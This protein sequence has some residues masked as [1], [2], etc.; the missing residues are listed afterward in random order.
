VEQVFFHIGESE[1]IAGDDELGVT[2]LGDIEQLGV[3][4]VSSAPGGVAPPLHVH[5]RHAEAFF[6]FE[7]ELTF[8]LEDGEHKAERET[9]V[10]I[11]PEVVH[12]FA[13]TGGERAHFLDFHV[14]S[15][16]FGDF[17]R[18]LHAA[19]DEGELRAVRAAFD[20]RP[21]PEYA[22]GD[23]GLAVLRRTGGSSGVGSTEPPKSAGAGS[24][25][26]GAG[27]GETIVDRPGRRLTLLVEADELTVTEFVHG[28]GERGAEP[29]IHHHH[30]DGFLVVEGELTFSYR[31]GS[32]AAPAGTF[33]LVPP[34]VVHGF[35]NEGTTSVRCFNFHAP[36][37]GFGDHL[38]QRNPDFDQHDP[39]ADGGVDPA[40]LIAV[41]LTKVAV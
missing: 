33:L 8:R 30:A 18:G 28:P 5:E 17:A 16:G 24:A 19:R 7:G 25:G 36:S 29:H 21:A 3:V 2:L 9:W 10:F 40:S 37:L 38:R 20:Q 39:P 35:D 13:V 32:F 26:A 34:G 14:P 1:R 27:S 22:A 23:P 15:L 41:R 4:E 6:V 31:D 12:T 11:P